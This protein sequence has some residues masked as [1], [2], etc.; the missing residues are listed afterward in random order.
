M[1]YETIKSNLQEIIDGR[2]KIYA[3]EKAIQAEIN[4]HIAE[5]RKFKDGETVRVLDAYSNEVVGL[6]VVVGCNIWALYDMPESTLR[7]F[8][9]FESDSKILIYRLKK[10]KA[11]GTKSKQRF[12]K[13]C[14]IATEKKVST[15]DYTITAV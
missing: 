12:N 10:I 14:S 4:N 2:A 9:T 8:E 11:D 13:N 5:N 6:A 7:D 3:A 15:I 1:I